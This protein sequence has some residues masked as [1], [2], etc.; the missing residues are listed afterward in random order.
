MAASRGVRLA[1]GAGSAAFGIKDAGFSYFLLLFYS[2]VMGLDARLVGA[3]LTAALVLDALSDPVVG[4]WSDTFRSRWGRRHP[5]MYAALLPTAACFALLWNPPAWLS[6]TGLLV[7]LAVFAILT[8]T[9]ITFFETPSAALGPELTRD[10]DERS[11]LLA[12]RS[13]FGWTGGNAMTVLMF[14]FLFPAFATAAIA[15]GQF[16][17][18]AYRL[19]GLI[20]AGVMLLAMTVSAAGTHAR[21]PTLSSPP[22]SRSLREQTGLMRESLSN[23]SFLSLM[24]AGV[25]GAVASGLSSSLS[26]YFST[27]F[28]GFTPQQISL[29]TLAIF[30][31]AFAGAML[32]PPL[33]RRFGKKRAAAGLALCAALISP[34]P[35]ILR[36]AGVLGEDSSLTFIVV[37]VF[38]QID[39]CLVVCMQVLLVSM[40]SDVAEDSEV[41]TSRR[42]EGLFFSANTFMA[43]L[44]TGLGVM[45]AAQ[46]LAFARFP[47]GAQ[48]EE[49][50]PEALFRLGAVYV[51]LMILLRM[52]GAA[53]ILLYTLDRSQHEENLARLAARAGASASS[54]ALGQE[55]HGGT[56]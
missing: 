5:F 18:E 31:S 6:Q 44:V 1:Y 37:F 10:Y 14:A 34:A 24:G 45:A 54:E 20:A 23:P 53:M 39:V 21:I 32:A 40:M 38:G 19:Y 36:L 4:H 27:F 55:R 52:G 47:A 9:F 15:N 48:P 51:P 42:S 50:D 26:V 16:N 17:P 46:V 28:W 2:Q 11:A 3:I 30:F 41:R 22:P 49:I 8:R 7:W 13:F 12:Y 35:I 25:I 29:I 43:K 33:T 56:P